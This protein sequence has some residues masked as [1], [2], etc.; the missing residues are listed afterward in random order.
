[1]HM[2]EKIPESPPLILPPEWR[3][4]FEDPDAQA[5]TQVAENPE[6]TSA[7]ESR[8]GRQYAEYQILTE[9]EV[10]AARALATPPASPR[11]PA[12]IWKSWDT[13]RATVVAAVSANPPASIDAA[14]VRWQRGMQAIAATDRAAADATETLY[15]TLNTMHAVLPYLAPYSQQM[16]QTDL[17]T[18]LTDRS[19]PVAVRIAALN[20]IGPGRVELTHAEWTAQFDGMVLIDPDTDEPD[21]VAMATLMKCVLQEGTDASEKWLADQLRDPDA[22]RARLGLEVFSLY[23]HVLLNSSDPETPEQQISRRRQ[24]ALAAL[25][26]RRLALDAEPAARRAALRFLGTSDLT[27]WGPLKVPLDDTLVKQALHDPDPG[28]QLEAMQLLTARSYDLN[29]TECLDALATTREGLSSPDPHRVRITALLHARMVEHLEWN[30]RGNPAIDPNAAVCNTVRASLRRLVAASPHREV[31]EA[32]MDAYPL[33]RIRDDTP[34]AFKHT[35]AVFL[36]DVMAHDPSPDVRIAAVRQYVLRLERDYAHSAQRIPPAPITPLLDLLAN[37]PDPTVQL[38]V[39]ILLTWSSA[40]GPELATADPEVLAA[41]RSL[42]D[43]PHREL[44][45][46]AWS[47]YVDW[48]YRLSQWITPDAVQAALAHVCARLTDPATPDHDKHFYIDGMDRA[49]WNAPQALFTT[50]TFVQTLAIL[51]SYYNGTRTTNGGQ[52]LEIRKSAAGRYSTML[53]GAVR[54]GTALSASPPLRA[55]ILSAMRES[56]QCL[57]DRTCP[58]RFESV[59]LFV[60]A[61]GNVAQDPA[62]PGTDI[63][64]TLV[65]RLLGSPVLDDGAVGLQLTWHTQ[66]K[67]AT[68][69][70][71]MTDT[72]AR[73]L[74]DLRK[75]YA[76]IVF[77]HLDWSSVTLQPAEIRRLAPLLRAHFANTD[78]DIRWRCLGIYRQ[79]IETGHLSAEEIAAAKQATTSMPEVERAQL[80][81]ED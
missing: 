22:A 31:R 58:V 36:Q 24:T 33:S 28:V 81:P 59:L 17:R 53:L 67:P 39:V 7:A 42:L 14:R 5:I 40:V 20:M 3:Y 13:V 37:D 44:Q 41:L 8:L 55:E 80:F 77:D 23:L 79:Y 70:Q 35:E 6:M 47:A 61:V 4:A 51:R 54:A 66:P 38:A 11:F 76:S 16:L 30:A 68:W 10:A 49:I 69:R 21:A 34:L 19:L 46:R 12:D 62:F 48:T 26:A 56:R 63:V 45:S 73:H 25:T 1:M 65:Q 71:P 52:A 64:E 32:I 50:D 74:G 15:K 18:V 78:L 60:L 29:D 27:S 75:E 9:A 43:G 72:L 57:T 2:A